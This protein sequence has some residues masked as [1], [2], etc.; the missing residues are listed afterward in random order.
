VHGGDGSGT[1][2]IGDVEKGEDVEVGTVFAEVR[3]QCYLQPD[4]DILHRG[5]GDFI[6][7]FEP[8]AE[9][10]DVSVPLG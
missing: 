4:E 3:E 2:Q 1:T 5:L 9:A 7:D 8:L 10:T 6:A